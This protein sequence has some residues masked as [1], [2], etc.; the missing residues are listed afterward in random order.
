MPSSICSGEAVVAGLVP[1]LVEPLGV[2]V[3]EVARGLVGGVAGTGGEHQEPRA[4]GDRTLVAGEEADRLVD[5]VLREVV[6]GRVVTGRG[7]VGVV[8]HDLG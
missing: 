2:L 4:V 6:A 8:A 1:P 5:E 3:D 7:D